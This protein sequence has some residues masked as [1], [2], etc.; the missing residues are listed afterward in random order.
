[1]RELVKSLLKSLGYRLVRRSRLASMLGTRLLSIAGQLRN[2]AY[3]RE[4]YQRIEG[5]P[6]SIVEGG[7]GKGGSFLYFAY[8]MREEG[9]S[10]KLYG[11]DSF[12]G[13]PEPTP[14]DTSP[15][16]AKKG[17]WYRGSPDD[18]LNVLKTAGIPASFI[19]DHIKLVKGYVEDTLSQYDGAPIALLHVD[20]D[21]Y[22]AYAH[23]LKAM[24]PHVSPGGL[25]LFDEYGEANWPGA[26]KAVDEFLH[27]K[28]WV[29]E[30]HPVMKK[31]YFVKT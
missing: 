30:Q 6:G 14:E 29:L 15:R 13:F 20:L 18:I 28:P 22:S 4:M 2:F 26:T 11:F 5:V 8:L 24:V 27:G 19:D 16:N 7:V 9:K 17:Q 10:K 12:A 31:Y 1:M 25:V 21:L 3:Y 23:I